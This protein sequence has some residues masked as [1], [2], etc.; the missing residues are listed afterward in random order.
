MSKFKQGFGKDHFKKTQVPSQ[1]NED[2]ELNVGLNL[3]EN[4]VAYIT[5]TAGY[6]R[7]NDRNI[8]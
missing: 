6:Q 4:I 7:E 3:I 2:A 1:Y 8:L 5:K